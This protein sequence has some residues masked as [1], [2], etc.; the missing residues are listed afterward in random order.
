MNARSRKS[1][2]T[3]FVLVAAM[4]ACLLLL[5]IP[6]QGD[7]KSK[8]T[9]VPEEMRTLF[10]IGDIESGILGIY[11]LLVYIINGDELILAEEWF[12]YERGIGPVGLAVDEVNERL[13]VSY[14]SDDTIDAYN[15]RNMQEIGQIPLAGTSDLAGIEVHNATGRL[16]VV[17]RWVGTVWEFDTVTFQL[18]DTWVL[19]GCDGAVGVDSAGD[20][21]YVTC[22][23][24]DPFAEPGY[25]WDWGNEIHYYNMNTQAHLGYYTLSR[26][27]VG[28]SVT[29]YP[30]TIIYT[31]GH[32]AH[33]YLTKYVVS[34]GVETVAGLANNGKGVTVNAAMGYVYA[35][36]GENG[37]FFERYHLRVF[38]MNTLAELHSYTRPNGFFDFPS[39][40]DLVASTIPFGGTV[41]KI[42]TSHPSGVIQ[43][44][45]DVVFEVAVENRHTKAI[46]LLPLRDTYDTNHLTYQ[47]SI[48]ASNNNI[49]DGQI[50]W[51][52]LTSS[53]GYNLQPGNTMTVQLYFKAQPDPCDEFVE[54]MNLAQ[55]I[56]AEDT[57]GFTLTDAAGRVDYKIECGCATSADCDDGEFCNGEEYCDL[58]GRCQDGDPPCP[59]DTLFCTG[60]ESCNETLD[61]CET[62]GNPCPDDATFC[63]GDETCNESDDIC[64]HTGNPCP[65]DGLFC[66]G[67]ESCN[68]TSDQCDT[69]GDPCPDDGLFCNGDESCNEGGDTCDHSGDPCPDDALFCNGVESCNE[70]SDQ[71]DTTGDP[72]PDDGEFCNGDETCDESGDTCE[73]SG[74]PCPEDGLYCN[75]LQSCNETTDSC[76][77]TGDPCTD[78]GV[79]CNGD[80]TCNEKDD[81]CESSGDPCT[82]DGLYCNGEEICDEG[83][84]ACVQQ[85]VPACDDDGLYCNGTESC[86]EQ[87]DACVSSGDPCTDDGLFCNGDESCDEQTEACVSSGDPCAPEETCDEVTDSCVATPDPQDDDERGEEE[88][89]DEELWPKGEVTG[90]C[91]GCD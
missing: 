89:A 3:R 23:V 28:I 31:T 41:A 35:V 7:A 55:M 18:L 46:D 77:S 65:D 29:D 5:A 15:A 49:N 90:G 75:G 61:Q 85:N 88:G 12:A 81:A 84:G 71:C 16:F 26:A 37:P 56:G 34:S 69:T 66:N 73:H 80:E 70:T 68:E 2:T 27:S 8:A 87:A 11:P 17:D 52:D 67:A 47:Y 19:D 78:D 82:E 51:S 24:Y 43:D 83:V 86:D 57:S 48:P 44:G 30:E 50:D 9:D 32:F 40:T 74:D 64:E 38:N 14:E 36:D 58:D 79:F 91:C 1:N 10:M 4:M 63:N 59:D 13:F 22:G 60:V 76:N 6:T 21:L 20:I 53:F 62:S 39:P 25:E 72:C 42:C 33:D 45:D 54:G